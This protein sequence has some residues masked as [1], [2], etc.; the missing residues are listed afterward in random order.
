VSGRA[1][2]LAVAMLAASAAHAV[3]ISELMQRLAGVPASQAR[4]TETRHS[5]L[6]KTP[7]VVTGRLVYR[8]PDRLEKHVQSPFAE[9][10]VIEG[11]RVSMAKGGEAGR[12][13]TVPAGAAQ[14]LVESL[15]ATMAGDL[16][17]LERHFTVH[18]Q[19]SLEDWTLTLI[20][21]EAALADIVTRVEIA[22]ANASLRRIEVLEASGDR[23]VTVIEDAK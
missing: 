4:F 1:V 20:P 12:T 5:S 16:P 21:R 15:R 19:G 17:A 7:L 22:G 18:L 2:I 9:S 3:T 13:M 6:L 14:A 23:S 8:R 11:S 10:T